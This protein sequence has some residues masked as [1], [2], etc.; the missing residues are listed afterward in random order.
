M[1]A[2]IHRYTHNLNEYANGGESIIIVTEWYHEKGDIFS[3]QRIEM[4]S[5]I[6]SAAFCLGDFLFNPAALRKLA[7]DIEQEETMIRLK[8]SGANQ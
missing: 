3:T 4:H 2:P 1:S 5:Y 8:Y 7:D 6:N